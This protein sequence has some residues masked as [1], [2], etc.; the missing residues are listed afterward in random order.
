[1]REKDEINICFLLLIILLMF[2]SSAQKSGEKIFPY[3]IDRQNLDNGLN[4]VTV[5]FPSPGLAAFFIVVKAGSR[6]EI[7]EG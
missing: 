5:K 7:E 3:P 6:N 1:M 2:K 4:V